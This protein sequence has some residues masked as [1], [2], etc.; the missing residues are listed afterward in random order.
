MYV[1]YYYRIPRDLP[2]S[3]WKKEWLSPNGQLKDWA[4]FRV[5]EGINRSKDPEYPDSLVG[6]VADALE[7]GH[8][9]FKLLMTVDAEERLNLMPDRFP[10]QRSLL[11]LAAALQKFLDGYD[12]TSGSK[13]IY[14]VM[15]KLMKKYFTSNPELPADRYYQPAAL[16]TSADLKGML[17]HFKALKQWKNL[18]YNNKVANL[19]KIFGWLK[20]SKLITEN[21]MENE[22]PIDRIEKLTKGIKTRH[23]YYDDKSIVAIKEAMLKF[24]PE[25]T[26]LQDFCDVIYYTCTRP[27]QETRQLKCG[28]VE[29]ERDLVFIPHEIAKGGFGG[30]V[31]LGKELKDLF[32]KMKL[33]EYP[34]DYYIFGKERF[35]PGPEPTQESYF[36]NLFRTKIRIPNNFNPNF[37]NYSWKHTRVIHLYKKN[38]SIFEIQRLCRHQSATMTEEYLRDLGCIITSAK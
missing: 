35:G 11:T 17:A 10:V 5:K 32:L 3:L 28:D 25:G 22:D 2:P 38:N 4:R 37:T 23:T 30:P 19:T 1:Q 26:Y 7:N 36:S 34:K 24:G 21:P 6:I 12:Q 31:P 13:E 33:E 27:D 8:D 20:A 9:P 16:I 14:A 29:F 18:T 15:I